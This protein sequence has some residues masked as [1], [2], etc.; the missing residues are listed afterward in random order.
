MDHRQHTIV[1]L[2][3][4]AEACRL[5]V[6]CILLVIVRPAQPPFEVLFTK[7]LCIA[8]SIG[9]SILEMIVNVFKLHPNAYMC[10]VYLSNT[11]NKK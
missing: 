11:G 4:F 3:K 1:L 8:V 9:C 7:T 5:S 6:Y 10:T 2:G